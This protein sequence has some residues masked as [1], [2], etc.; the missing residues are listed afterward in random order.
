MNIGPAEQRLN[1]RGM[2]VEDWDL[3]TEP[4]AQAKALDPDI[5]GFAFIEPQQDGSSYR[6]FLFIRPGAPAEDREAFAEWALE[7]VERFM[8]HGPEPDGWQRRETDA[9][10]Q[11]WIRRVEL[12]PL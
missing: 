11:L 5:R 10:W 12:P 6:V 1:D 9:G 3:S 7:R 8:Q 2:S 4:E